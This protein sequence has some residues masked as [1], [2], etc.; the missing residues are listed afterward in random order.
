MSTTSAYSNS[1]A[2]GGSMD[3]GRPVQSRRRPIGVR[4][5]GT[6]RHGPGCRVPGHRGWATAVVLGLVSSVALAAVS[7]G[8]GIAAAL[9]EPGE[10]G[11][12]PFADRGAWRE[13]LERVPVEAMTPA[14]AQLFGCLD[15][16]V[17]A[18]LRRYPQL[19]DE[20]R[21]RALQ[22]SF[23][24]L[25]RDEGV[26]VKLDSLAVGPSPA[27]R[28]AALRAL[29]LLGAAGAVGRLAA[30]CGAAGHLMHLALAG[31]TTAVEVAVE[32]YSR[33]RAS[34]TDAG[35]E[36]TL[37]IRDKLHL[38]DVVYYLD[39]AQGFDFLVDVAVGDPEPVVRERANWMLDH[40]PYG[41]TTIGR[42][43]ERPSASSR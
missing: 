40:P 10:G 16:P 39:T 14:A 37:G 23:L 30:E 35:E 5:T 1:D 3:S 20:H 36:R 24:S 26:R 17:V 38:L 8:A 43:T 12:P 25:G 32:R 21:Y 11:C 31:D 34:G 7:T 29:T 22:D 9:E 2:G 19:P 28:C 6:V 33:A 42:A 4:P 18:L 13:A 15:A 41:S 27:L